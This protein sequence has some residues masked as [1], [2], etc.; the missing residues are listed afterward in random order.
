M[1]A[2]FGDDPELAYALKLSM[3]EEE[4]KRITISEEPTDK[5][6]QSQV[7]NIQLRLPDGQKLMRKFFYHNKI[8]DIINYIKK[9]KNNYAATIKLST[10]FPRKVFEDRQKTLKE[11]GIAKSETLNVDIK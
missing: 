3:I 1:Y 7:T 9:E 2:D 4:A 5:D 6:D 11:C 8:E 10:T